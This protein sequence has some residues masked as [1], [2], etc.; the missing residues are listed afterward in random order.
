MSNT[1]GTLNATLVTQRALE[2]V[3]TKRP[4][5]NMVSLNTRDLGGNQTALYNQQVTSRILS[6]PAVNTFNSGA[7]NASY[8]DVSVT[9]SNFKEVHLAFTPAEYNATSRNLLDEA[10]E[11]CAVAIANHLADAVA[12]IWTTTNFTNITTVASGWSYSNTLL[13]VR[14]ALAGR[15]VPESGWFFAMNSAVYGALLGDTTVVAALNNPSN[16]DAIK[17]GKLPQVAGLMPIEYP[18]IPNTGNMVGFAGTKDTVVLA[19]RVPAN[20]ADIM[21]GVPYPGTFEVV[22]D[23][24]TGFSV[25]LNKYI[26]QSDLSAN[27]RILVMYGVAKGAATN[28]QVLRTAA[29]A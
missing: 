8:T 9:M 25:V 20:P 17:T 4:L 21:P 7:D 2:L 22:T 5:L 28:G 27:Y 3:F 16:A 24:G 15:G 10:A 18:A 11:P 13:P 6:I 19:S 26:G 29:P 14:N 12:A 1:L 23:P